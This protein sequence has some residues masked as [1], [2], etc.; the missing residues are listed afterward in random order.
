MSVASDSS[1]K[2]SR[3][4]VPPTGPK[5]H[6]LTG[7]MREFRD[8]PLELYRRTWQEHGDLARIRAFPGV[9][10]YF[11]VHPEAVEH[12]LVRNHLNYRK[13]D[14]FNDNVGEL[15]GNGLITSEGDTWR[16]ERKL[17]QPA[18]HR[19][20]LAGLAEVMVGAT[21]N[22]VREWERGNRAGGSTSCPR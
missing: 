16:P 5:G 4:A 6:W 18:F 13:P 19:D 7:C 15:S 3:T 17:V 12:V 8:R 14:F 9:Y 10:V 21:E 22:L 20:R 2:E 11:L 1:S